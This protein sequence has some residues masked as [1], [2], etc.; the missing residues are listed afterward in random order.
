MKNCH[1]IDTNNNWCFR[2][3]EV[4]LF[5]GSCT[6]NNGNQFNESHLNIFKL[7]VV[8]NKRQLT[9]LTKRKISCIRQVFQAFALDINGIKKVNKVWFF[10]DVV[11]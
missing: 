11:R 6:P 1:L 4:R 8:K 7:E 9:F 2:V 5:T 3:V 10:L